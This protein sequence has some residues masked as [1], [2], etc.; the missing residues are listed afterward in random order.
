MNPIKGN[1]N[2]SPVRF[3]AERKTH[4][5]LLTTRLPTRLLYF[6]LSYL[7][8][9]DFAH[10]SLINYAFKKATDA[11]TLGTNPQTAVLGLLKC[12]SIFKAAIRECDAKCLSDQS[13]EKDTYRI[14]CGKFHK[15][16]SQYL[17]FEE[18]PVSITDTPVAPLAMI[19]C[20]TQSPSVHHIA[21]SRMVATQGDRAFLSMPGRD[22]IS[23]YDL[24]SGQETHRF[25]IQS[26]VCGD[27]RD[28]DKYRKIHS[29]L[30]ISADRFVTVTQ[31]G[32]IS[33]WEING[34]EIRCKNAIRAVP[35]EARL[36]F[37]VAKVG[38]L[39]YIALIL[40]STSKEKVRAFSLNDLSFIP[41]NIPVNFFKA[42]QTYLFL[43]GISYSSSIYAVAP[44][45]GNMLANNPTIFHDNKQDGI[46]DLVS[47]NDR[48]ALVKDS[49]LFSSSSDDIYRVLDVRTG[50]E[51]AN[52][53]SI[54][55]EDNIWLKDDLLIRSEVLIK[56]ACNL[57]FLHLPSNQWLPR[58]EVP[59]VCFIADVHLQI[60]NSDHA[61]YI[62]AHKELGDDESITPHLFRMSLPGSN[63]ID[64]LFGSQNGNG[65]KR[66]KTKN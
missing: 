32:L 11:E 50:E 40:D 49:Q 47:V 2:S 64:V 60:C 8:M 54:G 5:D 6:A 62:L 18:Y 22:E 12:P 4:S 46:V 7:D 39:L 53:T 9:K 26:A 16:S 59:E 3:E 27:L 65:H 52:F 31:G 1:S 55:E 36:R 14:L 34:K 30:P 23:I 35:Q 42:N 28:L 17:C 58:I 61:L 19:Q 51:V 63:G 57:D 24:R 37:N 10:L 41:T 45:L 38:N 48:W 13:Y 66:Q 20:D 56:N 29:C 44:N 15:M 21:C 33:I 25:D 43:Y